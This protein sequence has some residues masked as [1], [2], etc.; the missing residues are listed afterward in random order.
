[1]VDGF[2]LQKKF[3]EPEMQEKMKLPK[4][5]RDVRIENGRLVVVEK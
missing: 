4:F 1:M 2:F 3:A 5:I